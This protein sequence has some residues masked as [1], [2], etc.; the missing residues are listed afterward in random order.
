MKK[1]LVTYITIMVWKC[2]E[3]EAY[4]IVKMKNIG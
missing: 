1:F 2:R 4:D 3:R